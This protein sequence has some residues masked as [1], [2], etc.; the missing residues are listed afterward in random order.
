MV[1]AMVFYI[2]SRLDAYQ[3]T[4]PPV[5][6]VGRDHGATAVVAGCSQD[7]D[8]GDQHFHCVSGV[9]AGILKRGFL[10]S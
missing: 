1:M 5:G 4:G 7:T 8:R 10:Y 3:A 2:V 6:P 9:Y